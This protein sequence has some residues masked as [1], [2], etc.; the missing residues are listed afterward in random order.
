MLFKELA[1]PPLVWDRHSLG[2]SLAR[3]AIFAK[4]EKVHFHSIG[5]SC[6][7]VFFFGNSNVSLY[8]NGFLRE[9]DEQYPWT[10]LKM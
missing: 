1:P 9:I 4:L 8:G 5:N 3:G 10:F 2:R 7:F 6:F